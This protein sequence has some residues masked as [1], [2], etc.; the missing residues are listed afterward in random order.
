MFIVMTDWLTDWLTDKPQFV[1][2]NR[3]SR[4]C[5]KK[6]K[7]SKRLSPKINY[8][9]HTD[10]IIILIIIIIILITE[11]PSLTPI[12]TGLKSKYGVGEILEGTCIS[13]GSRPAANLTWFLNGEKVK[14]LS[15]LLLFSSSSSLSFFRK[16]IVCRFT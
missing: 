11:I 15:S 5:I 3:K 14:L 10:I 13:G 7:N 9:S 16:N 2:L 6:K 1:I 12:L 4:S 8:G